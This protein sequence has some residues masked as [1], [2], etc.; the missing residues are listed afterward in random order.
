VNH[1][2]G[3]LVNSPSAAVPA[4]STAELVAA[5]KSGLGGGAADL[6]LG[7]K[8]TFHPICDIV[9]TVGI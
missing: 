6:S 1:R 5:E 8:M 9:V 7:L 2:C 4:H 3:S